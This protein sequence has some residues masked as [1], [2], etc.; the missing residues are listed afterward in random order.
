MPEEKDIMENEALQE[1]NLQEAPI[2]EMK[3]E[4]TPQVEEAPKEEPVQEEPQEEEK[5]PKKKKNDDD[6]DERRK[7]GIILLFILVIAIIL[8]VVALLCLKHCKKPQNNSTTQPQTSING[9]GNG[10]GQGH[11]VTTT[12]QQQ[13]GGQSQTQAPTQVQKYT[14]VF[15]NYDDSQISSKEY[16]KGTAVADIEVPEDPFRPADAEYVYTFNGWD[17]ALEVVNAN[18]SYK[19]TYTSVAR[20]AGISEKITAAKA[21]VHAK[22]NKVNGKLAYDETKE[23]LD[24]L[25]EEYDNKLDNAAT[26]AEVNELVEEFNEKADKIY[27]DDIELTP[28]FR[29]YEKNMNFS[30]SPS[31]LAEKYE[32]NTPVADLSY[33]EPMYDLVNEIK[34]GYLDT[35]NNVFVIPAGTTFTFNIKTDHPCDFIM[36]VFEPLTAE[37]EANVHI[38]AKYYQNGGSGNYVECNANA[39]TTPG[40]AYN[41]YQRSTR[42][43]ID[44]VYNLDGEHPV[45][46]TADNNYG[47]KINSIYGQETWTD[48]QLDGYC[49]YMGGSFKSPARLSYNTATATGVTAQ[50][51]VNE[52]IDYITINVR[53]P[54]TGYVYNAKLNP[55]QYKLT[56]IKGDHVYAPDEILT[57]EDS[58]TEYGLYKILVELLDENIPA[59]RG[60]FTSNVGVVN[61]EA[62]TPI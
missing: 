6:D 36:F 2:E 50:E 45:T 39:W 1:Q 44:S 58:T 55:D 26:E 28:L 49:L 30:V 23:E 47:M 51:V 14:V 52:V 22:Y 12:T 35:E 25:K 7:K 10:G 20:E 9:G 11:E 38:S 31:N 29:I 17:S 43:Q 32:N 27:N 42:I 37:E 21:N 19:A 48:T 4:E 53:E 16:D 46:I 5:A 3:E 57:S 61:I 54:G 56:L 24:D 62:S 60:N 34:G 18:K 13:G 33:G 8:I 59:I 41:N 40:G 15:L